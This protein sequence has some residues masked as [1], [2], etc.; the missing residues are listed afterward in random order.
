MEDERRA[1]IASAS[2][3]LSADYKLLGALDK[4]EAL[5]SSVF[6]KFAIPIQIPLFEDIVAKEGKKNGP[7]E[8]VKLVGM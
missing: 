2:Q 8:K 1:I 5:V 6:T 3:D 4:G 7:K